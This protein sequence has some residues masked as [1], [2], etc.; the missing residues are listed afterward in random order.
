MA[1]KKA[2]IIFD[3]FLNKNQDL[4]CTTKNNNEV[5]SKMLWDRE[6]MGISNTIPQPD[7]MLHHIISKWFIS[8]YSHKAVSFF[9]MSAYGSCQMTGVNP[10]KVSLRI[11]VLPIV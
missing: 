7:L 5:K 4:R 10:C 11:L 2:K 6:P 3:Q 1:T 8:H 9:P